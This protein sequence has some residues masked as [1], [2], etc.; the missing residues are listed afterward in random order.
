M[1]KWND[2]PDHEGELLEE[3]PQLLGENEKEIVFVVHDEC[4][5]SAHDGKRIVWAEKGHEK[6][7]KK[8]HGQSI[9]ISE[10]LCECHGHMRITAAQALEHNFKHALKP[11]G[12]VD[13]TKLVAR[14]TLLI[15]AHKEGYWKN[16]HVAAQLENCAIP[17]FN[18]LH[19]NATHQGLFAFDNS[20]NH[21]SFAPDALQLG[22]LNVTDGGAKLKPIM[23]TTTFG[24]PPVVQQSMVHDGK[25]KGLKRIAQERGMYE[26]GMTKAM[27]LEVLKLQPDF[28]NQ[29]PWLKEIVHKSGHAFIYFPKYHCEFNWIERY[30]GNAKVYTRRNCD[31]TFDGLCRIVPE[32]LDRIPLTMMRKF[33]RKSYRY[34]DAYREKEG[35][36]LSPAMAEWNV[37]K[38]K[39]HRR[40]IKFETTQE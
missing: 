16:K 4:C 25:Q 40:I 27:L 13:A 32:A 7:K 18:I 3:A 1:R 10:F 9:M 28:K 17:I 37:K 36:W 33:A 30:W 6:I 20:S 8:S 26:H 24:N 21:R 19:P 15:G 39:S 31:Y 23:R 5:F 38:F 29:M 2:D 12:S 34:M 35:I 22:K 11:D 14:E